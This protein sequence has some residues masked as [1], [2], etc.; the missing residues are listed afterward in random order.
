MHVE[1]SRNS[2]VHEIPSEKPANSR[3]ISQDIRSPNQKQQKFNTIQ[4]LS[5]DRESERKREREKGGK[6]SNLNLEN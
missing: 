5:F 6:I 1:T 2:F 4:Q 3:K